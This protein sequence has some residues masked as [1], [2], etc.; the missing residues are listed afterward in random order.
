MKTTLINGSARD[1]GSC[2]YILDRIADV[3]KFDENQTV[4]YTISKMKINYCSGC[5]SCYESG[6]CIYHDDV[7]RIVKSILSSDYVFI[8]VP[9]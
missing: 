9:S 2:A 6:K 1:N 4:K 8:A 5:K 3:L 7:E